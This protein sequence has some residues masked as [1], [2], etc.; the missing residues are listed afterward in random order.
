MTKREICERLLEI[1]CPVTDTTKEFI[2]T[3]LLDLAAPETANPF[4]GMSVAD[5]AA[6][7]EW[8]CTPY[9]NPENEEPEKKEPPIPERPLLWVDGNAPLEPCPKCGANCPKLDERTSGL[10]G[11][12]HYC[13]SC[14]TYFVSKRGEGEK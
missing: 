6:N 13:Q 3:L 9:I 8:L 12:Y 10:P 14:H 4:K 11:A 2:R 5:L 7:A 1:L